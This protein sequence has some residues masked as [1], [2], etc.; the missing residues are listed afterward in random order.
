[1]HNYTATYTDKYQ[2][3]MAEVYFL[4]QRHN[5]TAVFDYFFRKP[6]F[7]GS[8]ALFAGLENLLEI[9]ENLK[10]SQ[11][12]IDFLHK[13]GLNADFLD[14]LKN[15]E[16]KGKIH[17]MREGEIVFPTEPILRVEAN[18][19]E[20]QIIET[21]LLNILNF[22][23]LIATKASRMRYVA[24]ERRLIDFGLRRAQANGAYYGARAAY[25][26]GFD[27][28]SNV[29]AAKDFDIPASGTM[30]H[31]FIQSYDDE[32][33]AFRR[34]AENRPNDCVLL[35][36]T[37]D[38]LK[39]GLPNAIKTGK[40]MEARGHKLKGIRLDSGDLAYL[41]RKARKM[42]DDAGLDYVKI[43]ASNQLDEH[44]IKSLNEQGAKIDV[45]GVG[46]NLMTGQP[47]AALDGV[48]KLASYDDEARIKLSDSTAKITLP[49][50][51]QVLRLMRD[52][53]MFF[54]ADVITLEDEEDAVIMHHPF[55]TLKKMQIRDCKKEELLTK[56]MDRGKRTETAKNISEIREYA[57]SRLKL[58]PE[59]HKRFEYP[60]I[61]KVGLSDALNKKRNHLIDL[62]KTK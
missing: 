17:S 18:I 44:L 27:A 48:F 3:T 1:M 10:F 35:A 49:D 11:S 6:P 56:V 24:G 23:T 33:T 54:G 58:L 46:T 12:D 43:A 61:Y 42:L 29:V 31:S 53:G 19:A 37:Y 22:Q 36:D 51:K 59:E 41:S 62:H 50:K 45:F 13:D 26:G 25:I 60:H 39:S 2:L 38:T 16:F 15:F 9:L 20:A 28:T 8:Y 55:E 32:L 34:F 4:E 7:K 5:H 52:N 57:Q 21:L 14:Y 40:E 30:A 47:D